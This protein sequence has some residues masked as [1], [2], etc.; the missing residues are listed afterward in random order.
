[1]QFE[2]YDDLGNRFKAALEESREDEK[3]VI[4][5]LLKTY[6]YDVFSRNVESGYALIPFLS[7]QKK[8]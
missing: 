6:V 3:V 2:V 1:M 5:R 7:M 8:T 4:E